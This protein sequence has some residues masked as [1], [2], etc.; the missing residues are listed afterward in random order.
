M[1]ARP[2]FFPFFCTVA[3][4]RFVCNIMRERTNLSHATR[5]LFSRLVLNSRFLIILIF[6]IHKIHCERIKFKQQGKL[7][8]ECKSHCRNFQRERDALFSGADRR[9]E[10][11]VR[12]G[13]S[14]I[15]TLDEQEMAL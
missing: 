11:G 3:I 1:S 14:E 8:R 13:L 10:L 7:V 5:T 12:D 9:K 2:V 4:V 6:L 15:G